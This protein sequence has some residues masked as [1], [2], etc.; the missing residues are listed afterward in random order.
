MQ[1]HPKRGAHF[2]VD[3]NAQFTLACI[4]TIFSKN[5]VFMISHDILILHNLYFVTA[6]LCSDNLLFWTVPIIQYIL[7]DVQKQVK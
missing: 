1:L 7:T 2:H 3:S 6:H 5:V 4:P